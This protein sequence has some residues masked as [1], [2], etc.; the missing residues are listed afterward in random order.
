MPCA[1]LSNYSQKTPM[2]QLAPRLAS[3]VQLF[4]SLHACVC[5]CV[6][7]KGV[8]HKTSITLHFILSCLCVCMCECVDAASRCAGIGNNCALIIIKIAHVPSD[9]LKSH[10]ISHSISQSV[11]DSCIH[12]GSQSGKQFEQTNRIQTHSHH[13]FTAGKYKKSSL[14]ENFWFFWDQ[15]IC[16]I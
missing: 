12:S 2:W 16:I 15:M 3:W 9:A 5:V 1:L 11:T 6:R 14:G 13:C 4:A 8:Q 10:W 7:G